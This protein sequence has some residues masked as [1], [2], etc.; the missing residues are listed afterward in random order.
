VKDAYQKLMD[1]DQRRTII[2]HVENVTMDLKKERRKQINA[3]VSS[4][5]SIGVNMNLIAFA[6]ETR[7]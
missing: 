1:A 6:I 3:G 4:R 5:D 2:M 7:K